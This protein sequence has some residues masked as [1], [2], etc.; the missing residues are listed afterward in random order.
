[1][2]IDTNPLKQF[3]RRPAVFLKLPSQGKDYPA[4]VIEMTPTGDI[5][6]YPMTA[7]DEITTK[8][9]DALFNGTA[10]VELIR[11]CVPNIKDPW[12]VSSSDLDAILIAI[13]SASGGNELEIESQCP[14]CENVSNYAV[15][16]VNVLAGMKAPDYS[17][18]LK[19][20]ELEIKFR[21][22]T[23]KEMNEASLGQF[24]VQRVFAA[25]DSIQDQNEKNKKGQEALRKVT[26]LTMKI[27]S[28]AIEYIKTPTAQV[29]NQ[30]YILDFL[31]NC[32]K[33]IYTVLRD[34][35]AE[36]KA[37]TELPPLDITCPSCTH[38]YKQPFTLN[39]TDFFG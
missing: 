20:S 13:K 30:D 11:S 24:E 27:L 21:P 28:K 16:L 35:N 29:D 32:D 12:K 14:S 22:L 6:V 1:M 25:L 38:Q 19:V 9:P 23:Y 3:F 36:L 33:T 10:V 8:T 39:A 17:N 26:E 5:P 31:H 34:Y 7:I 15:N 37:K 2:S 18:T 4:G